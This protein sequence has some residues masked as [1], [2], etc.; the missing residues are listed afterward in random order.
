M[1]PTAGA[2]LTPRQVEAEY[3]FA[4]KTLANWRWM[5]RGPKYSKLSPGKGGPVRYLREDIES[6]LRECAVT[7][8]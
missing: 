4:E 7:P 1:K 2:L 3:G 8:A 6:W 5:G